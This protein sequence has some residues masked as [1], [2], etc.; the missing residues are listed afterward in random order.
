MKAENADEEKAGFNEMV[1]IAT[2]VRYDM[3]AT[4]RSLLC[5]HLVDLRARPEKIG[6]LTG[7]EPRDRRFEPV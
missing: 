2:T 6:K 3:Y 4:L 5:S 7:R 1:L